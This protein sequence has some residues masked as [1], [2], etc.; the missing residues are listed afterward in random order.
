MPKQAITKPIT[1]CA[2]MS[3]G[4]PEIYQNNS[5]GEKKREIS[6]SIFINLVK[7]IMSINKTRSDRINKM[8]LMIN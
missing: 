8:I 1:H 4:R 7:D 3:T 6:V 5:V 2:V